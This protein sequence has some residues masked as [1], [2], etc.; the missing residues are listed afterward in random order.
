VSAIINADGKIPYTDV[1]IATIGNA[2]TGALDLGVRRGGIAPPEKDELDNTIP[3]YV[4]TLPKSAS[5]AFN[6][7]ANR[8]LNDVKGTARLAGA[9]HVVNANI[10]L[11]YEL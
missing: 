3:S 4:L 9:I 5:V 11:S 6:D 1:G 8:V 7:K 10:S 2:L